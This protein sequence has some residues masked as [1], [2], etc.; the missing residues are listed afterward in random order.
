V[1]LRELDDAL[2]CVRQ[3]DHAALS[4]HLARGWGGRSL[5]PL[6]PAESVVFAIGNHDAGWPDLDAVPVLDPVHERP[7]SYRTHPL[8]DALR[9]AER[10][11]ARVAAADPYAGWLVSRH[12]ASFHEDSDDPRAIAWIADQIGHRAELLA[13]ARPHVGREALHPHVL[14]ANFDWLQLL[15]ALSLALCHDWETWQSRPMALTYGEATGAYRY[16]RARSERPAE[17]RFVV[18]GRVDPW[19][20]RAEVV[21]GRVRGRLLAG[22]TWDDLGVLLEAWQV[23]PPVTLEV[24]LGP[25]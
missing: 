15:D 13:R 8:E 9:V 25:G 18:E 2:F 5:P 3:M 4:G 22:T 16:A 14:E 19:P 23:A 7:H 1:I 6:V 20:F 12:F 11:V 17:T 10:S 21:E 24:A